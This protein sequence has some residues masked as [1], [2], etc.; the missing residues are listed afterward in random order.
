M[1]QSIKDAEKYSEK[2]KELIEAEEVDSMM[3]QFEGL[4]DN[5]KLPTPRQ[6][7]NAKLCYVC[8]ACYVLIICNYICVDAICN[9]VCINAICNYVC[10]NARTL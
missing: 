10:S 7:C 1:E 6:V 9:Y 5:I 2:T 3:T 8:Y 4:L